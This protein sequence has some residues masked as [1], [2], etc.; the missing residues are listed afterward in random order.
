MREILF[1]GKRVDTGEWVEGYYFKATHHWHKH[2]VHQDWIATDSVQNGGWCNVRGKYAIVPE[3]LGQFTG[4]TDKNG[5]RIFEGDIVKTKFGRL[6]KMIWRQTQ[7]FVGWDFV[8][9][10]FDFGVNDFSKPPS[11]WD[12][13]LPENL[14]VLGN[15]IDFPNC[16]RQKGAKM[17]N[18]NSR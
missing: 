8:V 3:T 2:G 10:D 6:C 16:S 14:E 15:S 5:K 9:C 11:G 13:Y 1:R 4:L 17:Q 12:L 7:C 18:E